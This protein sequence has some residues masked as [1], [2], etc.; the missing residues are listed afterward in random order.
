MKIFAVASM[1]L[2]IFLVT[3]PAYANYG[4]TGTVTSLMI[5]GQHDNLLVSLSGGTS[6]VVICSINVSS[7]IGFTPEACKAAYAALLA[8]KSSGQTVTLYFSDSLTCTTQPQWTPYVSV[9]S[10]QTQ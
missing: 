10:V 7:T 2:A 8:A 4:C 9:Y 3:T 6:N 1:L 5:D